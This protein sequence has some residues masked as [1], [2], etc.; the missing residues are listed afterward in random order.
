MQ[1]QSAHGQEGLR[2]Q[3]AQIR[4]VRKTVAYTGH[5]AA[6][7]TPTRLN[8]HHRQRM[9]VPTAKQKLLG[10]LERR[11]QTQIVDHDQQ[12]V[13][14]ALMAGEAQAKIAQ[15]SQTRLVPM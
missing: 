2:L 5:R 3:Q 9:G 12:S 15:S 8:G 6:P 1:H 14:E 4:R 7:R 11:T 13:R 10:R